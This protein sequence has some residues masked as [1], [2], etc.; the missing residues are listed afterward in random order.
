MQQQLHTKRFQMQKLALGN[1]SN[2]SQFITVYNSK[3][4]IAN[5]KTK[6]SKS[7]FQAYEQVHMRIQKIH[8]TIDLKLTEV[9][10]LCPYCLS[11]LV[12]PLS[13]QRVVYSTCYRHSKG[14][15][16]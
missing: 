9:A 7:S 13:L 14:K 10:T 4:N 15:C 16:G 12:V 11:L 6:I 3:I 5:I 1:H 2:V 8:K